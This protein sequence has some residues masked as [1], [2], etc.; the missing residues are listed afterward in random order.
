MTD[1][2][3]LRT[4]KPSRPR[5]V[6]QRSNAEWERVKR[7]KRAREFAERVLDRSLDATSARE[8]DELDADQSD[9]DITLSRRA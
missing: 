2:V 5:P 1:T 3:K 6:R 7:E 9:S 4:Q 8:A